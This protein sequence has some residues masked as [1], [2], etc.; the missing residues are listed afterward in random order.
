MVGAGNV[1]RSS[2][3]SCHR[4][5]IVYSTT[6]F[7][8]LLIRKRFP[9]SK[10]SIFCV[11]TNQFY[12]PNYCSQLLLTHLLPQKAAFR[13]QMFDYMVLSAVNRL[14][15]LKFSILQSSKPRSIMSRIVIPG[16]G[17]QCFYLFFQSFRFLQCI[18]SC[19]LSLGFLI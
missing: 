4:F 7:R 1:S 18:P 15:V 19:F 17:T 12:P 2:L 9:I 14:K 11:S 5:M 10:H 6:D 3:S 16:C 13:R 8:D